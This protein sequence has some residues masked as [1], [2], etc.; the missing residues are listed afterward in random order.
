MARR[1]WTDDEIEAAYAICCAV[2][3]AGVND[4]CGWDRRGGF[5]TTSLKRPHAARIK[6]AAKIAEAS[7]R[8]EQGGGQDSKSP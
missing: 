3:G 7:S 4:Y 2:C 1:I 5:S 8:G 6:D